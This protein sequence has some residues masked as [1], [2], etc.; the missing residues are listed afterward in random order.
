MT[1]DQF[2]WVPYNNF[3][4]PQ[5]AYS[6]CGIWTTNTAMVCYHMVEWH[7]ADRVMLQFGLVQDPPSPPIDMT[8]FHGITMQGQT[9]VDW[10]QRHSSSIIL[11]NE[12][13]N[14][15]V[16]GRPCYGQ[17]AHNERYMRWFYKNSRPY[18]SDHQHLR[19]PR[20]NLDV[21]VEDEEEE[22]QNQSQPTT[23]TERRQRNRN[24]HRRAGPSQNTE[25]TF[26]ETQQYE[27]PRHS[28]SHAP[29]FNTSEDTYQRFSTDET[30]H[31]MFNELFGCHP[32]TPE[33]MMYLLRLQ[34]E[35]GGA[36]SSNIPQYNPN[37]NI[38]QT[39]V[40]DS[41]VEEQQEPQGRR[42]PHRVTRPRRCGT[43]SHLFP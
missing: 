23:Q 21:R 29:T 26:A 39:N 25:Q 24:R 8:H 31:D 40:P 27:G 3:N 38:I 13:E 2:D 4:L 1:Q 16:V 22:Q 14:R 6:D 36:S 18:I 37:P 43:G 42:R 35:A 11:W 28:I 15:C 32:G 5:T 10:E 12:R 7:H 20:V 9:D 34:Q 30:P 41:E 33:S 19:D 17:P